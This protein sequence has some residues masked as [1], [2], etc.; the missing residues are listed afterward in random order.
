M[1]ATDIRSDYIDPALPQFIAHLRSGFTIKVRIYL[2][3][4]TTVDRRSMLGDLFIAAHP[5]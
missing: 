1:H 3:T 2:A 5:A 4:L